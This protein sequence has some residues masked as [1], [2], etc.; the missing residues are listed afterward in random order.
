MSG[1]LSVTVGW[2]LVVLLTASATFAQTSAG[3]AANTASPAKTGTW[4]PDK[5]PWGDP[6]RRAHHSRGERSTAIRGDDHRSEDVHASV[7]NLDTVYV[8]GGLP[9]AAVRVS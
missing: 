5:T 9:G 4:T 2:I 8:A 7:H 3:R 1:R 6:D